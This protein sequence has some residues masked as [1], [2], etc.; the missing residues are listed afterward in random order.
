MVPTIGYGAVIEY[1]GTNITSAIPAHTMSGIDYATGDSFTNCYLRVNG[2]GD[3]WTAV[4]DNS[5]LNYTPWIT[6]TS[7][8]LT[9]T[10]TSTTSSINFQTW[11]HNIAINQEWRGVYDPQSGWIHQPKTMAERIKE[12]IAFRNAP[13][14]IRNRKALD[15]PSDIREV[16]ARETLC[17][18]IGEEK[19][20][21]FLVQGHV[22]ARA[23]SG[24]VYQIFPGQGITNVYDKGK[25]VERLCVVLR[26]D[27]P[28]TDSLIMRYL[29]ILNN[30]ENF[31]SYAIQHRVAQSLW[32]E[33]LGQMVDS[34]KPKTLAEIH[35]FIKSGKHA[36][37]GEVAGVR[38]AA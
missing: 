25:K 29:M 7:T 15:R 8:F 10:L 13:A 31:R 23:K 17:R 24:L 3:G 22:T 37:I 9:S 38:V 26:G 33:Y 30:E 21:R 11:N 4:S 36:S 2:L 1:G 6:S 34:H 5:L 18:V 14:F 35:A 12:V 20:R 28:P 27:F 16:R 32:P 19:Y